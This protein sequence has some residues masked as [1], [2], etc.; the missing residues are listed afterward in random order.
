VAK[1][2]Q[3]STTQHKSFKLLESALKSNSS[4]LYCHDV[5]A[6]HWLHAEKPKELFDVMVGAGLEEDLL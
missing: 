4:N 2:Q 5:D 1:C 6:G 3:R